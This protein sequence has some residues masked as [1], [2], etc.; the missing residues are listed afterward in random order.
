MTKFEN[1]PRGDLL[2]ELYNSLSSNRFKTIV[3]SVGELIINLEQENIQK[4][5]LLLYI[6]STLSPPKDESPKEH[7]DRCL[8]WLEEFKLCR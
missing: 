5:K 6:I 1:T 4:D 3:E 7:R 8:K 2:R